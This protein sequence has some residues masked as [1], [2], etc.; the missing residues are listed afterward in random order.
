MATI[1]DVISRIRGQ[2]KAESQ[3]AFVTDRY[4]YSLVQKFAQVLMRRQDSLNKLMKFN[5]IWKSLPY[6]ELIE[7][8]RVE[9]QCS[10][11]KSGCTFMRTKEKLPDMIEGFWGPLIRSVSSIDGSEE[12]Q[13]IQP[14]TYLAMAKTTL[15]R[16][17]KTKYFWF[18]D[19]YLYF[20]NL[21]WDAVKIE[22]VFDSDIS[23]WQCD[24]KCI[25][26]YEQDVNIPE[27]LLAEIEGQVLNIMTT[28]LKIP[29]E[30]SDNKINPHR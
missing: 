1:A 23:N 3:D 14:S 21:E 28:T 26:H 15:F 16:Y 29:S 2:V 5:S 8:D 27:S 22:A 4:V 18:I 7:V 11:I 20:P 6:V 17:N 10:G 19:H 24:D 9:A 13:P 12:L 30:D 25:P